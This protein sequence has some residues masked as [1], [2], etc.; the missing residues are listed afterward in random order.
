MKAINFMD[1]SIYSKQPGNV[2]D[3]QSH[4]KFV[5]ICPDGIILYSDLSNDGKQ[6]FFGGKKVTCGHHEHYIAKL[7]ENYFPDKINLIKKLEQGNTFAPIFEFLEDGYIIF[8]N[9]QT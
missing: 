3:K 8:N 5:L 9:I 7:I 6:I 4:P 2:N 1:K